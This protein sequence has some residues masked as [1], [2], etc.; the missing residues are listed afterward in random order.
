MKYSLIAMAVLASKGEWPQLDAGETLP[1]AMTNAEL[2]AE[3]AE[4]AVALED[5][6]ENARYAADP[7][8]PAADMARVL[9]AYF[10]TPDSRV[11]V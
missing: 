5:I 2:P 3:V 11:E 1:V 6:A 4:V 9:A 8:K 7:R 10:R